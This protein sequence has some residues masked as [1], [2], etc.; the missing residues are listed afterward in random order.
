MKVIPVNSTMDV[1]MF[2]KTA[3]V[4]KEC[5]TRIARVMWKVIFLVGPSDLI[6]PET[7]QTFV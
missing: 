5:F 7:F 1:T 2:L 3:E 6:F 4:R